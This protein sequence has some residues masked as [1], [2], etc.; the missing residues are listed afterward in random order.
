[1]V[2]KKTR[3]VIWKWKYTT[4]HCQG[5]KY[6]LEKNIYIRKKRKGQPCHTNWKKSKDAQL[7]GQ[8]KK[9]TVRAAKLPGKKCSI[10]SRAK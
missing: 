6:I 9:T 2:R 1:M 10:L 5:E 8:K 4:N 7:V 3:Q